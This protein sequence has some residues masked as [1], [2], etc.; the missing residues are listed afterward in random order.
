MRDP[1]RRFSDRVGDYVRYR[2]GYPPA[3]VGLFRDRMS[4]GPDALVVDVGSGT[5]KL[6]ELLLDAGWRVR[7]VEPNSE[8]RLAAEGLLGGR[9]GFVSVD[10]R[11]EATT[12]PSASADLVT[13]AQAF[14]WFEQ[15]A[16]RAEFHRILRP[17]GYVALLWNERPP[18]PAITEDYERIL[19]AYSVDYAEVDRR[20]KSGDEAIGALLGQHEHASF[21]NAQEMDFPGLVGRYLSASYALKRDDPRFPQAE[22]ALR[23]LHE[24]HARGSKLVMPTTTHVYWGRV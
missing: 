14:H 20:G 23:A 7:A 24:R 15:S 17:R 18:G 22:A 6:T 1:T 8:M 10:G 21:D 16:A 2:P 19:R 9:S 5:G 4:L 12:L 11:A 3:V 13:A